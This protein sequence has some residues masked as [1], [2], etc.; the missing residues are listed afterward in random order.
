MTVFFS[1]ILVPNFDNILCISYSPLI[2]LYYITFII[3]FPQIWY[4]VFLFSLQL[5]W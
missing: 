5:F 1:D 4:E 2:F 3:P